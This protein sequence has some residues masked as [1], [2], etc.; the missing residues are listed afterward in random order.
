MAQ[1][2]FAMKKDN[3]GFLPFAQNFEKFIQ[4]LLDK[5]LPQT[6]KESIAL[7]EE[8]LR[9]ADEGREYIQQAESLRAEIEALHKDANDKNES[10]KKL[11]DE[12]EK[13][14]EETKVF[15][16]SES[17]RILE[18]NR[19]QEERER[20]QNS[21]H[22]QQEMRHS[23]QN[24]RDEDLSNLQKT[25]KADQDNRETA[26]MALSTKL[27]VQK[28]EIA[29]ATAEHEKKRRDVADLLSKQLR[30]M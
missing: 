27:A 17:D 7:G 23:E 21:R 19:K 6:L 30:D 15:A 8:E 9:K 26:L 28:S 18:T 13:K 5:N 4:A 14:L 12:A 3:Q 29:T 16:R 2:A 24:K 10:A 25:I 11:R 20:S 1:N 22:G